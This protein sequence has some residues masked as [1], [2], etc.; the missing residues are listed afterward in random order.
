LKRW[1]AVL[2]LL[3][4]IP[5]AAQ[6]GT[7]AE[8]TGRVTTAGQGLPGVTVTGENGGYRFTLLPPADYRLRFELQGFT[9]AEKRVRL[10]LTEVVRADMEL[11]SAPLHEE[12][13]VESK[14]EHVAADASIAMNLPAPFLQRLPGPRDIRA[15][16]LLSPGTSA[17]GNH[18]ALV[19]AGAPSWDSLFL[20]DGV[21][22]N[23]Y[24]SGQPHD[25]ILEDAIQEIAVLTGAISAEYGRF[26][27]G[28]VSTLTKSGGNVFSGSLRDTVTNGA[29]TKQTPYAGQPAAL[30]HANH[31]VEGTLGGFVLKD[32][33]WFFGALRNAQS[34]VLGFTS[35]TNIAYPATSH[36]RRQEAKLTGQINPRHALIVS[37]LG[38]DLAETN[39]TN[40]RSGP[41]VD[42][43]S[44]IPDRSQPTRLL[45]ATYNGTLTPNSVLEIQFS[46]KR[47]AL[48]GNGGRSTDRIAGTT[49][50]SQ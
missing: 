5:C 35:M 36:D 2:P 32:R 45:S 27:G 46:K 48:V 10:S 17:L 25:V 42:L 49:I 11:T 44:L 28:V 30:N 6:Q 1:A 41:P 24:L 50:A 33:L 26:T 16:T 15:A 13:V 14:N 9:T 38:A 7:T 23:E 47:Y 20:V 39:V 43:P 21:A 34:M 29:W 37:Y 4:V 40:F 31:A 3:I 8:L 22:A 18:N 19:I 12:I